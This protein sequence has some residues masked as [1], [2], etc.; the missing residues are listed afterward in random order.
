MRLG[1]IAAL[2]AVSSSLVC[3]VPAVAQRYV[4]DTMLAAGDSL[5]PGEFTWYQQ[6]QYLRASLGGESAISIIVSI[7]AQRAYVYRG[8]RLVAVS[9]VST[10]SRGNATPVGEFT[11]LQKNK[12]HRSNLYSNAPMP[13]MQRLT[14]G[15][16]ALHGGHLPGYPASHGCIRLPTAFARELFELTE[17]GGTVSVI[18]T[19]VIAPAPRRLATPLLVADARS[20]GGEAFNVVTMRD[21]PVS[22][23]P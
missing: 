23:L 13:Y 3:A 14:W 21:M 7:P 1:V 5:R 22:I 2:V 15:G 8:G 12:F 17:M 19:E 11:I 9:T 10:G 20:L 16:I 6:P 4:A 18:D